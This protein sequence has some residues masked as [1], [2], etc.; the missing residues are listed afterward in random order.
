MRTRQGCHR[1]DGAG[2][3]DMRSRF[4]DIFDV[5]PVTGERSVPWDRERLQRQFPD[6]RRS[7]ERPT[8]PFHEPRMERLIRAPQHRRIVQRLHQRHQ[9]RGR[10]ISRPA[11][12]TRAPRP[13]HLPCRQCPRRQH[14]QNPHLASRS[15]RQPAE[16][17]Q[18]TTE[19]GC[20]EACPRERRRP[21]SQQSARRRIFV[22]KPNLPKADATSARLSVLRH[23][24]VPPESDY[25]PTEPTEPA[26][27]DRK[28]EE[29]PRRGRLLLKPAT[30]R[31]RRGVSRI[32]TTSVAKTPQRA[33]RDSNPQPSDP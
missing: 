32:K 6:R 27:Q 12:H 5:N 11:P 31:N 20:G 3:H 8:V 23:R 16:T 22:R 10:R 18:Q 15:T 17:N 7:E 30:G 13:A 9:L 28:R 29:P 33:G 21:A 19:T 26:Q 25:E 24:S 4:F 1:T 14:P 2:P